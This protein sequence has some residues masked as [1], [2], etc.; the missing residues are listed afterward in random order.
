MSDVKFYFLVTGRTTNNGFGGFADKLAA[1]F[2]NKL[3]KGKAPGT[4]RFIHFDCWNNKVQV[5]DFTP[6]KA[7]AVRFPK[8]TDIKSFKPAVGD[9]NEDPK[10]FVDITPHSATLPEGGENGTAVTNQLFITNVYHSVRGAP[11]ESVVMIMFIS[12]GFADGPVLINT[13]ISD[14]GAPLV[15]TPAI[16]LTTGD[17]LKAKPKATFPTD[18]PKRSGDDG[19]GRVD[20][21]FAT[22]MGEDPSKSGIGVAA[23]G[24]TKLKDGGKDALNQFKA[25]FNKTEI[26]GLG[27]AARIGVLG[28]NVQEIL[29]S[30]PGGRRVV[31]STVLEVLDQILFHAVIPRV[32]GTK[33]AGTLL[34]RSIL[35][36]TITDAQDMTFDLADQFTNE[37]QDTSREFQVKDTNEL[38]ILHFFSDSTFFGPPNP[39]NTNTEIQTT[40]GKVMKFVA[41]QNLHLYQF[42]AAKT[43]GIE[44]LSTPAGTSGEI[45]AT[46]APDKMV[47]CGSTQRCTMITN[48]YD[49]FLGLPKSQDGYSLFDSTSVTNLESHS[50]P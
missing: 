27:F 30:K 46:K 34:G 6:T 17:Q 23:D 2:M 20:A 4:A 38:R 50:K 42:V 25:A 39:T 28:C 44:V 26:P 24:T 49:K 21:D 40:W 31:K 29:Y 35:A 16:D 12:H 5:F 14:T 22:N 41:R 32:K 45:E 8:W 18:L 11:T 19:D 36:G 33:G 7:G 43:L 1:E 9:A 10:T 3:V 37:A 13:D 48:I 47:A 15:P